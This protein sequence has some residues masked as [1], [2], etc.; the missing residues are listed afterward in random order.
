MKCATEQQTASQNNSIKQNC[1]LSLRE[2]GENNQKIQ[3]SKL[4]CRCIKTQLLGR[5]HY[6]KHKIASCGL[7]KMEKIIRKYN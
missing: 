6:Q 2:N 3:L 4:K 1:I 5:L 7:E